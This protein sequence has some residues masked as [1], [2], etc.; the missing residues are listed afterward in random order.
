VVEKEY[1]DVA[2]VLGDARRTEAMTSGKLGP[3]YGGPHAGANSATME[4]PVI[5]L[6]AAL[7]RGVP[8]GYRVSRTTLK[9]PVIHTRAALDRGAPTGS[10]CSAMHWRR[11]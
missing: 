7:D 8:T 3:D 6:R 5:H 2:A 9:A 1:R 4:E 10:G 11:R